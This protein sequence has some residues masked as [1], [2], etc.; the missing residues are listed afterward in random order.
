M[1]ERFGRLDAEYRGDDQGRLRFA[2]RREGEMRKF[3]FVLIAASM[4]VLGPLTG[5]NAEGLGSGGIRDAAE[6]FSL[7]ETAACREKRW[8][9]HGWGWYPCKAAVNSCQKCHWRWG[10]KYCWKVC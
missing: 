10:Y 8:G 2:E 9:W 3:G 1:E 4:L 6:D 7:L 5:S